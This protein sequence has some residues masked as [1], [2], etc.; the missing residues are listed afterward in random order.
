M[1]GKMTEMPMQTVKPK[2][3]SSLIWVCSICRLP[4]SFVGTTVAYKDILGV[5]KMRL[6]ILIIDCLV[7]V[8]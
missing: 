4:V 3:R 5:Q 6:L 1:T 2:I 7:S 8:V